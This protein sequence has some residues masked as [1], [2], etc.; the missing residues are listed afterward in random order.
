M[1][2]CSLAIRSIRVR[3]KAQTLVKSVRRHFDR[4]EEL[5]PQNLT[6]MHG[7]ELL[8][9]VASFRRPNKAHPKLVGDPGRVL[10]RAIA[11]QCLKTVARRRPQ[12]AEV[13]RRVEVAQFPTR[14]L[15]KVGRKALGTLAIEDGLG[16]PVPGSS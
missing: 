9:H 16:G 4:N 5:L 11:V 14:H 3:G 7:L 15:N 1:A 12:V 6:G 13:A 8:G 2:V 10:P